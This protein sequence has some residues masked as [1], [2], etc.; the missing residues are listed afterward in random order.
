MDYIQ[1]S[2]TVLQFIANLALGKYATSIIIT[3]P[4]LL[5]LYEV[6][7]FI[8]IVYILHLLITL[9]IIKSYH[10]LSILSFIIFLWIDNIFSNYYQLHRQSY[11]VSIGVYLT[12]SL[13]Y[14]RVK[15]FILMLTY[16]YIILHTNLNFRTLLRGSQDG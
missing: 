13:F 3:N 15:T 14:H 2:Y 4:S 8:L 10:N 12:I 1:L 16:V 6:S 9:I 7:F 5:F 11:Y